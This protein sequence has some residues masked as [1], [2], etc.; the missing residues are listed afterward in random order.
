VT[1]TDSTGPPLGTSTIVKVDIASGAETQVGKVAWF[2]GTKMF[3]R[4]DTFS[5]RA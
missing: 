4:Q 3:A 1:A 2:A 5:M